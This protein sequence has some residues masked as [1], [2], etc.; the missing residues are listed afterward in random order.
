[1]N[2]SIHKVTRCKEWMI[3]APM[4]YYV[5]HYKMRRSPF[6]YIKLTFT[7]FVIGRSNNTITISFTTIQCWISLTQYQLLTQRSMLNI[8]T[9]MMTH[10]NMCFGLCADCNFIYRSEIY[11]IYHISYHIIISQA[12]SGR[13]M[14]QNKGLLNAP[15]IYTFWL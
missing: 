11:I 6:A 8:G 9:R 7:C 5:L 2:S 13:E 3:E 12:S 4:I 1:M 10:P 15:V 14:D